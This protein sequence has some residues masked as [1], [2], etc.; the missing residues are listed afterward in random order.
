MAAHE[1]FDLLWKSGK[2]CRRKA[3]KVMQEVM[4]MT[5]DQAHIGCFNADQCMLLIVRIGQKFPELFQ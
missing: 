2:M 1:A 3:Y 5:E 4:G